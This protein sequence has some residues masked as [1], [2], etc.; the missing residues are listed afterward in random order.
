MA[1]AVKRKFLGDTG[2]LKSSKQNDFT[3]APP[4]PPRATSLKSKKSHLKMSTLHRKLRA[5]SGD[6][7]SGGIKNKDCNTPT[8]NLLPG[9]KPKEMRSEITQRN[10]TRS[11]T[12]L[13]LFS[14]KFSARSPSIT[15]T[16]PQPL[17]RSPTEIVSAFGSKETRNAALRERGL[18]PPLKPNADLSSAERERDRQFPVLTAPQSEE[19]FAVDEQGRK[20]SAAVKVKQEWEAKYKDTIGGMSSL[21]VKDG[22]LPT[23]LRPSASVEQPSAHCETPNLLPY[24]KTLA[25]S[26]KSTF[27]LLPNII[28]DSDYPTEPQQHSQHSKPCLIPLPPSSSL[29][30]SFLRSQEDP[31]ALFLTPS[32]PSSG[33]SASPASQ[34]IS[35]ISPIMH[36]SAPARHGPTGSQS[37]APV[38]NV[39]VTAPTL[40]TSV[41]TTSTNLL[42][43]DDA[44]MFESPVENLLIGF[45]SGRPRNSRDAEV[46]IASEVSA[47]GFTVL[48]KERVRNFTDPGSGGLKEPRKMSFNPFKRSADSPPNNT[49]PRRLS[50]GA[51]LNNMRRSLAGT[52][53]RTKVAELVV[54]AEKGCDVSHLPPSPTPSAASADQ[55]GVSPVASPKLSPTFLQQQR[56]ASPELKLRASVSPTLYS[57]GTIVAETNNIEDEESRRVTELAFLG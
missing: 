55:V 34:T 32:L 39:Q 15:P 27:T 19:T 25:P 18:L 2:S 41:T 26:V 12:I 46:A 44:A 48:P 10:P 8:P 24:A 21:V 57:R 22:S 6:F 49:L 47:A 50:M 51:S 20:I 17:L 14:S 37:S 31:S 1:V 45:N 36:A 28:D 7:N 42:D 4:S 23:T 53:S 38:S 11:K 56:Q 54:S 33:H 43:N 5:E 52:F 35:I 9:H 13:R 40:A 3:S 29:S 30:S 16:P